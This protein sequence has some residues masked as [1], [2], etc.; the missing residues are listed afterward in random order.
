MGQP[1]KIYSN[2]VGFSHS[3][4]TRDILWAIGSSYPAA[5]FVIVPINNV[6]TAVFDAPVATV[7]SKHPLRVGLFRS[8]AGN[9]I[10]DVTRVFTSF[11]ISRLA[12]DDKSLS[13]VRKV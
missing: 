4:V 12:L 1:R 2:A 11:F 3:G 10:G 13:D 8:S 6:M 5:V 7:S 9:A